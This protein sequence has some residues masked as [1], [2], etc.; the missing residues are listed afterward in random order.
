MRKHISVI[1]A[2]VTMIGLFTFT[3]AS[4]KASEKASLLFNSTEQCSRIS[5][6]RYERSQQLGDINSDGKLDAVDVFIL[7][8]LIVG[9]ASY[10]DLENSELLADVNC[11]G[12]PDA[13]DVYLIRSMIVGLAPRAN[14]DIC[15]RVPAEYSNV[16]NSAAVTTDSHG[17]SRAY[18]DVSDIYLPSCGYAV[19]TCLTPSGNGGNGEAAAAAAF[20]TDT[21]RSDIDLICDGRF[22][23][24][25]VDISSMSLRANTGEVCF[26]FFK[27]SAS[28][29]RMFINSV[30]FCADAEEAAETAL[31]YESVNSGY[32]YIDSEPSDGGLTSKPGYGY[33]YSFVSYDEIEITAYNGVDYDVK[34][35]AYIDGFKVV[36]I[37]DFTMDSV[38]FAP[39]VR[40][41]TLPETVTYIGDEAFGTLDFNVRQPFSSLS[42]VNLPKSLKV[43]GD[44]AFGCSSFESIIIPEGVEY[45]GAHAF[46]HS[47]VTEVTYKGDNVK[48]GDSSFGSLT[49]IAVSKVLAN[50]FNDAYFSDKVFYTYRDYLYVYTGSDRSPVIPDG[51]SGIMMS[52]FAG[53]DV[54]T[55]TIPD[56][57][58]YIGERAFENSPVTSIVIPPSVKTIGKDAFSGCTELESITF[59][60]GLESI[61]EGAFRG[62]RKLSSV[63]LPDGLLSVG[64]DAFASCSALTDISI[65]AS[66]ETASISSVED[67]PWYSALPDGDMYLGGVYV[68]YRT[69]VGGEFNYD[70]PSEVNILPGTKCV[71]ILNGDG[72]GVKSITIPDGVKY[73]YWESASSSDVS[74]LYFPDSVEYIDCSDMKLLK[75]L[76]LPENAELA[77]GAFSNCP[78]LKEATV[79]G[80]TKHA[81]AFGGCANIEK[82]TLANGVYEFDSFGGFESLKS[83][84]LGSVRFI[85]NTVFSASALQSVDIP[86]SVIYIGTG[87]FSN[88]K[89]LT[90]VSGG[91]NVKYIMAMA[92]YKCPQ[93][94]DIGS[95]ENSVKEL[96]PGAFYN[97]RWYLT[98]EK[99][100]V[101]FGNIA[102][103]YKGHMP[104]NSVLEFREG[105]TSVSSYFIF[106]DIDIMG[107]TD[108]MSDFSQDNLSGIVLPDSLT[109]IG[110]ASF[111][112]CPNLTD[113]DFGKVEVI[114]AYAFAGAGYK[115]VAMPD[116]VRFIGVYAFLMDEI[117][118]LSL[119]SGVRMLCEG[120]FLASADYPY[121]EV[122]TL[123]ESI[124]FIGDNSIGC[125][126]DEYGNIRPVPGITAYCKYD[127]VAYLYALRNSFIIEYLPHRA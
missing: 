79:P 41:V 1:L 6:L 127:T 35:P 96:Y 121:P 112:S 23:S 99:G 106:G 113:I 85:G 48:H 123:P 98:Q 31:K 83:V 93:L 45:I 68:G 105:T 84:E 95:L 34:V 65:P 10:S 104:K 29:D 89:A 110:V 119:G 51:V 37:A 101:Y 63:A 19:I 46:E 49:M 20:G 21:K 125:N 67:T 55:V 77:Y 107:K 81:N 100:I 66:C 18:I 108:F 38:N 36:G 114:D 88:C 74:S 57:V 54:T 97:T 9:L 15:K 22:H 25:T 27:E 28:G 32:S 64:D 4:V 58:E 62:C 16:M 24:Y 17:V 53:R 30:V 50:S 87:A 80:G 115:N 72:S 82:L 126:I 78:L 69:T 5:V 3:A 73:F 92:F 76:R 13:V 26:D 8:S 94:S 47:R 2:L 71:S 40:S 56:S 44:G 39:Y 11:D 7:R 102:Y 52:A 86:E 12:R 120:A 59:S 61:E 90:A 118:S 111:F 60:E 70:L 117:S 75:E 109:R 116:T 43:I 14:T 42:A 103:N 122:I 91:E 124:I 33:S